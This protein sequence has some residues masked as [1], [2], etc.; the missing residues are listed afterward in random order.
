MDVHEEVRK[1]FEQG[2]ISHRSDAFMA[3]FRSTKR[4]LCE[5]ANAKNVE[6][7]LDSRS[8]ANDAV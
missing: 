4:L 1:A 7:L 2:P 5:L 3:E 6:V 8:L